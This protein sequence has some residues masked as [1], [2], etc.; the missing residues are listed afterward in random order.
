M[1]SASLDQ[2][3]SPSPRVVSDHELFLY[4]QLMPTM[5]PWNLDKWRGVRKQ[6][7]KPMESEIHH[8]YG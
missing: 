4:R 6:G 3:T 2:K 8:G 5:L 1:L 7:G